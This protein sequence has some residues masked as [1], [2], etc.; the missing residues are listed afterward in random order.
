M[1][2]TGGVALAVGET[3]IVVGCRR[4]ENAIIAIPVEG[5]ITL[6]DL[7]AG[8]KIKG[9]ET[10]SPEHD[11]AVLEEL[12]VDRAEDVFEVRDVDRLRVAPRDVDY[13]LG[14]DGR[15]GPGVGVDV[16]DRAKGEIGNRPAALVKVTADPHVLRRRGREKTPDALVGALGHAEVTKC[17]DAGILVDASQGVERKVTPL[18]VE[19]VSGGATQILEIH[20]AKTTGELTVRVGLKEV[21][22]GAS[23]GCDAVDVDV[24]VIAAAVLLTVHE[25]VSAV[26]IAGDLEVEIAET[27]V[28]RDLQILETLLENGCIGRDREFLRER[29]KKRIGDGDVEA[30]ARDI[31]RVQQRRAGAVE[32]R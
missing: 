25:R 22:I 23:V 8:A 14:L 19:H 32:G 16:T 20:R 17:A 6:I 1:Q 21:G 27:L 5:I 26:H 28:E 10:H 4:P 31:D 9:I 3:G 29:P 24:G 12:R 30:V 11:E 2:V 18:G 7:L 15:V 13:P